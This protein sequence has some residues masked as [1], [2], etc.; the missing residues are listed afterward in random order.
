MSSTPTAATT[1]STASTF[2]ADSFLIDSRLRK[3]NTSMPVRVV[4]VTPGAGLSPGTVDVLP[5]VNQ[6]GGGGVA[7][8]H[9]TVHGLAVYR[10][11]SGTSAVILSPAVGD[12]GL[13]IFC[14]HDIS[15]VKATKGQANPGSARR[16]SMSDGVYLGGLLNVD[17]TQ[18]VQFTPTGINIVSPQAVTIQAPTINL[19]GNVAT[20]GNL[21]N[22]GKNIDSTHA[23]SGVQPG[24]GNSGAPV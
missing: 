18:Y 9:G 16:F 8:P 11:Q 20:T 12:T 17:P 22:N 2:N 21:T 6:V 15:G 24:Q 7:Y 10:P 4:A 14:S 5:L 13:A 23:H 1:Q 19:E 3:I